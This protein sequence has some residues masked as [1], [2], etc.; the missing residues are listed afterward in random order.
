MFIKFRSE[1]LTVTKHCW[2]CLCYPNLHPTTTL[3]IKMNRSMKRL[4]FFKNYLFCSY[5]CACFQL[6]AFVR[7]QGH[8]N[9]V[10]NETWNDSCLL[11]YQ[12]TQMSSNLIEYPILGNI[13]VWKNEI[14]LKKYKSFCRSIHFKVFFLSL[15]LQRKKTYKYI[16]IYIY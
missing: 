2:W 4:I 6:V 13:H 1:K 11:F 14:I 8:M 7:E 10:L 15:Y 3:Y 16:Y 12:Q 9:G 5:I